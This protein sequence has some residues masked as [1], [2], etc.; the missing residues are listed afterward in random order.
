MPKGTIYRETGIL[1]RAPLGYALEMDGGGKW[2]LDVNGSMRTLI[3]KRVT[4]EG[5]RMGF[6]L[7]FVDHIWVD[8]KLWK[9]SIW[10]RVVLWLFSSTM[11]LGIVLSLI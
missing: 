3:G 6:D 4:V 7:I 5:K 9:L 10:K 1:R 2:M 8:G 11:I